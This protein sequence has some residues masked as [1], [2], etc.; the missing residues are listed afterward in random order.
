MK[1]ITEICIKVSKHEGKKK[2]TNISQ[3]REIVGILSDMMFDA[4]WG[5]RVIKLMYDNG[6][7]RFKKRMKTKITSDKK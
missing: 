7:R 6:K 4:K 1:N 2:E 3:I 5:S